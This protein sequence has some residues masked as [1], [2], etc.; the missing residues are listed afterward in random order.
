VCFNAK[1]N[2]TS[3]AY[4]VRKSAYLDLFAGAFGHTYGC[5]DIWQMYSPNR[6][7]VNGPHIFWQQALDLPGALEMKY[8]RRLI[9]S[10]PITDRVPDQSIVL[11]NAL[12][13]AERVQATRGKDYL[14]VYTASGKAFSVSP[15]KISGTNL[16]AFWYDPRSGKVRDA[17]KFDNQSVSKFVPPTSGYG[18]DWVLVI[19]DQAKGYKRP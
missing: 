15:G 10:R 3:S 17:G 1:E 2:G 5:H 6:E 18:H 8:V 13:A 14:F 4:D 7:A 12:P 19:D 16:D 11:E 9:E